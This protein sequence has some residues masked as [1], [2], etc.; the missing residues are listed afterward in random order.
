MNYRHAYHAGGFTDVVK[1]AALTLV[2]RRLMEKPTPLFVLDTHAGAGR[3][4]L[5][6]DE[7]S[8]TG[9]HRV[10]IGRVIG[11]AAAPKALRPYLAIVGAMNRRRAEPRWY[12]GSSEIVRSL[13]R[14]NDRL[15]AVELHPED[16][17]ALARSMAADDRVDV[18]RDDGYA[19]LKAYLPPPER[20][21]LV[22]IDPPFELRDEFARIV[23][24]L[25][26]A[27]RRWPTGVYMIWYP[28]KDRAP[29][30]GFHDALAASGLRRVITAE[31]LLRPDD[32]PDRLNGCGLAFVNLPWRL[33]A[34]LSELLL[35]LAE[36]LDALPGAG[37]RVATLI[38]E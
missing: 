25:K 22:L 35:A 29:V 7:A 8:K 36:R 31:L 9:E 34:T 5:L 4:D 32:D 37:A 3:Y 33:D 14:K 18:R 21:G 1:H 30:A 28:I 17:R 23:G 24:G 16:A 13:L 12:P 26:H 11:W 20:R 27:W 19:A 6:G 15:V 10:G 2:L 38:G